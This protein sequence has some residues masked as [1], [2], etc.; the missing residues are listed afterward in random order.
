MDS[1]KEYFGEVGVRLYGTFGL[2]YPIY[3]V[4]MKLKFS[5]RMAIKCND[6]T[7][8]DT[9]KFSGPFNVDAKLILKICDGNANIRVTIEEQK[10]DRTFDNLLIGDSLLKD[11]NGYEFHFTFKKACD[12]LEVKT[13]C[14]H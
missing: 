8:T 1:I 11:Y 5:C 3:D 2:L 4:I 9:I 12:N 14:L 7:Y 13:I 10:V 6:Y